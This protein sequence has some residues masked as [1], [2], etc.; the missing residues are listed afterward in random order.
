MKQFVFQLCQTHIPPPH[1]LL[2]QPNMK[3]RNV[4]EKLLLFCSRQH[5]GILT[6]TYIYYKEVLLRT[7]WFEIPLTPQFLILYS[8]HEMNSFWVTTKKK[9]YRPWH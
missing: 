3:G 4:K 6:I 7:N 2:F 8:D 9:Q 1:Q 5:N